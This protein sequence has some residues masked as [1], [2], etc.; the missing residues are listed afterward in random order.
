MPSVVTNHRSGAGRALLRG[1][2]TRLQV[3]VGAARRHHGRLEA[4]HHVVELLEFAVHSALTKPNSAR[5]PLTSSGCGGVRLRRSMRTAGTVVAAPRPTSARPSSAPPRL[6]NAAGDK[7]SQ[8]EGRAPRAC[9]PRNP[10][11]LRPKVEAHE[12]DPPYPS[13]PHARSAPRGGGARF[14][15]TASG[16]EA[17][18][19]P[20][21]WQRVGTVRPIAIP[22]RPFGAHPDQVSILGLGGY[23]L[24][25]VRHDRRRPSASCTKR[26]TPAINFLDNAWEYHDG[27]SEE[28]MG[29]AIADRRRPVFLMTK[30]CTH[31]RSASSRDAAARGVAAAAADR[32]PG[33]VADPRVR[34]RQRPRSSLRAAAAS[35]RRSSAPKRRARCG[36]SA[37]PVTRSPEIHLRMLS[38]GFPF[39]ACQLPLNGFDRQLPQ[40]SDAGL[41][42]LA[43]RRIAAIGMKSLGGDGRA[44]R[45]SARHGVTDALALRHEPPGLHD[46]LRHR[47]TARCCGR[48]SGSRAA[49]RR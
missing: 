10:N 8:T 14:A 22:R 9:R 20:P 37:S 30:V 21:E 40:L 43:R 31:G 3:A 2:R 42:E 34:V 38:F 29:Q 5:A 41:P 26:S 32:L 24:G 25:K 15:L 13:I 36:M 7:Q 18:D 33:P 4:V 12:T 27:A 17:Y 44:D 48:T 35:W 1:H 19:M 6:G 49:S 39:D 16:S 46:G 28:R 23:H 45:D 47:L 11:V